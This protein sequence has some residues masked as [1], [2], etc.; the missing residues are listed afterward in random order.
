[1]KRREWLQVYPLIR[2]AFALIIGIV[3]GNTFENVVP[4]VGWL[5]ITIAVLLITLLLIKQTTLQ[6]IGIL[7]TI[8]CLGII[9]ISV[10]QQQYVHL[11]NHESISRGIILTEPKQK[12][13]AVQC[14]IYV[15]QGEMKGRKVRASILRDNIDNRYKS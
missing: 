9:L 7:C 12:G 8:V 13:K 4:V 3:I 2:V 5:I 15:V 14:D 1:M 11:S 10:Q 6:G